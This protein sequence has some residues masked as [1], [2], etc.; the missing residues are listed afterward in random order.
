MTDDLIDSDA[1]SAATQE[2]QNLVGL[3]K[4]LNDDVLQFRDAEISGARRALVR[5]VFAYIEGSSFGFRSAA[6]S[7][8]RIRNVSLTLAETLMCREVT[9]A[10]NER[11]QVEEKQVLSPSLAN[12]R[13]ALAIFSKV[14]GAP[15]E[16]PAG[17]SKFEG[18]QVAQRIRNRLM[19]PRRMQELE[20]SSEEQAIVVG[21]LDWV[22]EQQTKVLAAFAFRLFSG[23]QAFVAGLDALPK[24]PSGGYA[25]SDVARI[26][27]TELANSKPITLEEAIEWCSAFLEA[28]KS[29]VGA[30]QR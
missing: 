11:G 14:A 18:L 16:F 29:K 27:A 7:L 13:F 23:L 28:Q 8:A 15:Y 19:H 25:T 9:Y 6:L 4:T 10:L 1:F 17:D 22:G 3:M 26:F 30:S 12:L 2:L 5:S 20:V 21:A 24:T